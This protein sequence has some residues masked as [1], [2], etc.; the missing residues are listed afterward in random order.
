MGI[1]LAFL[2]VEQGHRFAEACERIACWDE[3][4]AYIA[5]EA[6][7]GDG[8]GDGAVVY[9]LRI[10][11]LVP[12]GVAGGV[13]VGDVVGVLADAGYDVAIHDLDVEDVEKQL[14]PGR[15]DL[16][17]DLHAIIGMVALIA[18]H[19]HHLY[20]HSAIE[21]FQADID[22]L[23]L[24]I[25]DDFLIHCRLHCLPHYSKPN[26]NQQSEETDAV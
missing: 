7:L 4:V 16:L 6:C 5:G 10:I 2:D 13:V 18:R 14:H 24:G 9:F 19:A 3:L 15:T 22:L 12:T 21:Y 17:D 20:R 25:A 23:L 11:Q 8:L 26:P 1:A